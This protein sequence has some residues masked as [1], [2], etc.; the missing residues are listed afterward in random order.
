MAYKQNLR[1]VGLFSLKIRKLRGDELTILKSVDSH[2][3]K[4]LIYSGGKR[5]RI[6][7]GNYVE[8]HGPFCV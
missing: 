2:K 4:F 8:Y 7:K 1:G 5:R 6:T 3:E